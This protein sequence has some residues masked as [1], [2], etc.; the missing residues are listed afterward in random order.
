MCFNT[1]HGTENESLPCG[2]TFHVACIAEFSLHSG[3]HRLDVPCFE[4]MCVPSNEEVRALMSREVNPPR[5]VDGDDVEVVGGGVDAEVVRQETFPET[6]YQDAQSRSNILG[7]RSRGSSAKKSRRDLIGSEV[8]ELLKNKNLLKKQGQ[9]QKRPA[10]ESKSTSKT[11]IDVPESDSPSDSNDLSKN[12]EGGLAATSEVAKPEVEQNDLLHNQGAHPGGRKRLRAKTR[13]DQLPPEAPPASK[14]Q[15]TRAEKRA[16]QKDKSK[17][18]S[19]VETFLLP[20]ET[21]SSTETQAVK[22]TKGGKKKPKP[23]KH[24]LRSVVSFATMP[25]PSNLVESFN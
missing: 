7:K 5:E 17:K 12:P 8:K 24:Q 2:H 3:V 18:R 21:A 19:L 13:D 11:A 1:L 23:R 25:N 6:L 4:C 20:N 10:A 9:V 16:A 14:K 22:K 15:K